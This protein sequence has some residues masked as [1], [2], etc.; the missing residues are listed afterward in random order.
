MYSV[1][2]KAKEPFII[3]ESIFDKA[4]DRLNPLAASQ[5]PLTNQA[6]VTGI[7]EGDGI[8]S[9]LMNQMA[10]N[11]PTVSLSYESGPNGWTVLAAQCNKANTYVE[12]SPTQCSASGMR[13]KYLY[14]SDAGG[15]CI[16]QAAGD[17][18]CDPTC[19]GAN[20]QGGCNYHAC[21][22]TGQVPFSEVTDISQCDALGNRQ[23]Y[24]WA[25]SA[26]GSCI[27]DISGSPTCDAIRCPGANTLNGCAYC[28]TDASTKPTCPGYITPYT[29]TRADAPPVDSCS[30]YKRRPVSW[31]NSKATATNAAACT[32]VTYGTAVCDASC[33][34]PQQSTDASGCGYVPYT[35]TRADAPPVDSCSNYKR[36]PVSWTNPNKATIT[37]AAACTAVTYGTSTC[38]ASC[39]PPQ[40]TTDVN[41][42]GYMAAG[43]SGITGYTWGF[44]SDSTGRYLVTG[45]GAGSI[46][47][48]I[49]YGVSWIVRTNGAPSPRVWYGVA[50]DSTGRYLV[51]VNGSPGAIYTSQ[52]YGVSWT[53]RTNGAPS[54]G[55]WYA[56]A[57]SSNGQYLVTGISGGSIYRSSDYGSNWTSVLPSGLSSGNWISFASDSTGRYLVTGDNTAGGYMYTSSDYG[58]SWQLNYSAG[59][60]SWNK[61]ASDSTG[62]NL[63]ANNYSSGGGLYTST[64]GGISWIKRS[65]PTSVDP[66]NWFGLA[67]DSTGNYL[68]ATTGGRVV[69]ST[70]GGVS[71]NQ[72]S[73][74]IPA[75]S[76]F[77]Q[78]LTSDSTGRYLAAWNYNGYIYTS[79][80][81]GSNWT[82]R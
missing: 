63:I 13:Q 45:Q 64:N 42:C 73:T 81:Y 20:T 24:A 82:Q 27:Q 33:N 3:R 18:E 47:T 31:T 75:G 46:Y 8:T 70:N 53:A 29:C 10:L 76:L 65:P 44:A 57:S 56:V 1:S 50:S 43:V 54:A 22:K 14:Q 66:T 12:S 26:S 37:N 48:S 51:A 36:R 23:A 15:A 71:W 58:A 41:A 9:R 7:S 4:L 62:S 40:Q 30:N 39:N 52:N 11:I 2:A 80:N 77:F 17:P 78:A 61:I 72:Q 59:S 35:C 32:A 49:D 6:V 19:P 5:N 16:Q 21:D 38:D 34:P 28:D 68:V 60:G 25:S 79:S 67:S 69:T 74:G 55:S